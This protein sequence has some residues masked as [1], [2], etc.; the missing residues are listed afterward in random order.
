MWADVQETDVRERLTAWLEPA[1]GPGQ[2]PQEAG[3]AAGLGQEASPLE[4]QEGCN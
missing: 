3:G 1:A 4:A 2:A